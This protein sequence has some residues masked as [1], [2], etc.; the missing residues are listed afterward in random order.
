MKYILIQL[1][2]TFMM[3]AACIVQIVSLIFKGIE[4]VFAKG[5]EYLADASVTIAAK[6]KGEKEND[7]KEVT[8]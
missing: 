2:K 8:A 6:A 3:L 7:S 1:G 5:G 4:W